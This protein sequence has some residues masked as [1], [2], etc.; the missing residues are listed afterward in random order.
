MSLQFLR[1]EG[2]GDLSQERVV[3]RAS[4]DVDIGV[5]AVFR[6]VSNEE[7]KVLS[8]PILCAYWFADRLIKKDDWV[9]LYSKRGTRSQK[10]GND[11]PSSYFYYWGLENPIWTKQTAV[12]VAPTRGWKLGQRFI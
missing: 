8:G 11:G 4:T 7:G 2:A 9:I 3:L 6:C 10:E 12:V 1:V 5:Y